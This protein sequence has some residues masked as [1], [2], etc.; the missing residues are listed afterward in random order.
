MNYGNFPCIYVCFLKKKEIIPKII[1]KSDNKHA[2]VSISFVKDSA[3]LA[4]SSFSLTRDKKSSTATLLTKWV[5]KEMKRNKNKNKNIE[6]NACL[7]FSI[8]WV[9]RSGTIGITVEE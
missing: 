8:C 6:K 2:F 3:F 7:Y 1:V 9:F 4:R 5:E